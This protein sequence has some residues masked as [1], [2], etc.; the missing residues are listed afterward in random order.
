MYEDW[1]DIKPQAF[2]VEQRVEASA[3]ATARGKGL[4]MEVYSGHTE[5]YSDASVP[6]GKVAV[7]APRGYDYSPTYET[8][9]DS[10]EEEWIPEAWRDMGWH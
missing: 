9:L 5:F 7:Y 1:I 10:P 8:M 3:I 4:R 2:Y 6:T